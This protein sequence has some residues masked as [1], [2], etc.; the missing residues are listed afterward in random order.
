MNSDKILVLDD[1]QLAEY[2]SPQNLL[3]DLNSHFTELINS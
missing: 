3:Y 2:D 1:G